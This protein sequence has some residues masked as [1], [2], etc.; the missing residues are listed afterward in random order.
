[1]LALCADGNRKTYR[2]RQSKER[3]F[4]QPQTESSFEQIL[5]ASIGHT[6]KASVSM[7][8]LRP[9][10]QMRPFLSVMH[11]KAHSTKCQIIWQKSGRC[12]YNCSCGGRN[13]Q[14]Q[15]VSLWPHNQ[16]SAR[17]DMLTVQAIGWKQEGLQHYP[18]DTSRSYIMTALY[19]HKDFSHFKIARTNIFLWHSF[20]KA[21]RRED[22]SSEL[23]CPEN[24]VNQW[25]QDVR[26]KATDGSRCEDQHNLQK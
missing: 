9:L 16:V 26:Q 8:E 11:A 18:A 17:N 21:Q 22:L 4:K 14:Q 20:R 15:P 1:M 10:L 7:L 6:L 12:W 23:G 24:I 2:F 13:G 3:S 5:L 25:V 19:R